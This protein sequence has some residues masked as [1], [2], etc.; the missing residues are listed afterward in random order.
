MMETVTGLFR[1][2]LTKFRAFLSCSGASSGGGVM[3]LERLRGRFEFLEGDLDR[4][5]D[6]GSSSES[7]IYSTCVAPLSN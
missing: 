7:S 3:D 4:A 2:Y 6:P 1:T 5:W